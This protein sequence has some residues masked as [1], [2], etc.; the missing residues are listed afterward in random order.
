LYIFG[1]NAEGQLC[2]GQDITSLNEPQHIILPTSDRIK[3][4]ATHLSYATYLVTEKDELYVAGGNSDG[5][6]SLGHVVQVHTLEKVDLSGIL[7]GQQQIVSIQC[8][9]YCSA[10]L[11][12]CKTWDKD[13]KIRALLP[14]NGFMD[15]QFTFT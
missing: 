13:A 4:I 2:V 1:D 3:H 8:G 9:V 12:G 15:A 7:K 6:L 5:Q 10:L 11:V 14:N